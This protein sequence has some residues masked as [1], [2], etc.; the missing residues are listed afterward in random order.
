VVANG[1]KSTRR[2]PAGSGEASRPGRVLITKSEIARRVQALAEEILRTYGCDESQELTIVAIMTGSLFF[3]A[4][5]V[6]AMECPMRIGIM[7]VSNYPG[8]ATEACG[9]RVLYDLKDDVAGKD[10]LVLDDILDTGQTLSAVVSRLKTRGART[11]RTCVLL[12]KI[13]PGEKLVTPDFVGFRIPNAFVV[14]YGLDYDNLYRNYPEI[15][16]LE[17]GAGDAGPEESS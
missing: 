7:M 3:L 9:V 16:V 13:L 17:P 10:V 4:D 5:L 6:R 1:A 8:P 12:D 14:G 2:A 11:V 15:A